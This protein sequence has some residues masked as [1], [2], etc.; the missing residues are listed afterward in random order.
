MMMTSF[1]MKRVTMFKGE[2]NSEVEPLKPPQNEDPEDHLS[3]AV[4]RGAL[5]IE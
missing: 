3:P 5:S 2:L 1:L 4:V